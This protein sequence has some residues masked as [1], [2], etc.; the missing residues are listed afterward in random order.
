MYNNNYIVQPME[1]RM[2]NHMHALTIPKLVS[3][4]PAGW[5]GDTVMPESVLQALSHLLH[6]IGSGTF[7]I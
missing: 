1:G 7:I 3:K 2:N 4:F 5:H 6:P